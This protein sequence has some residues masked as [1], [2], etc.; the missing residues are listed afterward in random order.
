MFVYFLGHVDT[1]GMECDVHF[2]I[3]QR[4]VVNYNYRMRS[5]VLCEVKLKRFPHDF[6]VN[7]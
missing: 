3:R 7:S 5:T 4:L 6:Q 2:L 1:Q